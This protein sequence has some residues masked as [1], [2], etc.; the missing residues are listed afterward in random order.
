[1][2]I[3]AAPA[4]DPSRLTHAGSTKRLGCLAPLPG[5]A[6]KATRSKQGSPGQ[7][8]P[9]VASWQREHRPA[10]GASL[11]GLAPAAAGR[12][13]PGEVGGAGGGLRTSRSLGLRW[14]GR[15]D[16]RETRPRSGGWSG[17]NGDGNGREA[18][19]GRRL[20][21]GRHRA[22]GR[23]R[24]RLERRRGARAGRPPPA[25]AP[26]AQSPAGP[27]P[28]CPPSSRLRPPPLRCFASSP[29]WAWARG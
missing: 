26:A 1:M 14:L 4:G 23:A 16:R 5:H 21:G 11:P 3:D 12:G 8:I 15:R 20:G 2:G 29:G 19:A 18:S 22:A 6:A 7:S 24:R 9:W 10:G 17:P 28:P 27:S 25:A 13:V